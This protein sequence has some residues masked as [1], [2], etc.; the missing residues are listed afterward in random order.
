[1]T[2]THT[3][4]RSGLQD[5]VPAL[6]LGCSDFAYGM[7]IWACSLHSGTLCLQNSQSC[8]GTP[9]F[10]STPHSSCWL[11]A[12]RLPSNSSM[13]PSGLA[14][15]AAQCGCTGSYKL[16]KAPFKALSLQKASLPTVSSTAVIYREWFPL[17]R[18]ASLPPPPNFY[19][20]SS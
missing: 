9:N 11:S 18:F 16:Y 10:Q 1:M 12:I 17:P 7:V 5:E 19:S 20:Y 13:I 6:L 14:A 15:L 3:R 2:F 4:K 8:L